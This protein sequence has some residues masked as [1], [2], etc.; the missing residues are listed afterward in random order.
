MNKQIILF[1]HMLGQYCSFK[2]RNI[3]VHLWEVA[4]IQNNIKKISR[5][6]DEEL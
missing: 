1:Y 3:P 6:S 5:I 4:G 2:G